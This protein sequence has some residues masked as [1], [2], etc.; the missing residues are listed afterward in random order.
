ML[1]SC[2]DLW[3]VPHHGS[4]QLL[5]TFI[6]R[7][8]GQWFVRWCGLKAGG[9]LLGEPIYHV[10]FLAGKYLLGTLYCSF[11][12]CPEDFFFHLPMVCLFVFFSLSSSFPSVIYTDS[13]TSIYKVPGFRAS[14]VFF[15][16][17]DIKSICHINKHMVIDVWLLMIII[18]ISESTVTKS[19]FIF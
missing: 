5:L 7:G 14:R 18:L 19:I 15:G 17:K 3:E 12:I 11:E 13:Y 6:M 4:L 8:P 10:Y 16:D 2:D 1:V 9:F